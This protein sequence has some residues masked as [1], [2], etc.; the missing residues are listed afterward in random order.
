M[1][2]NHN[3]IFSQWI[4]INFESIILN[5]KL[6]TCRFA[7][8][9]EGKGK[10][11]FKIKKPQVPSSGNQQYD[12][13]APCI[14]PS[15]L[16]FWTGRPWSRRRWRRRACR[17]WRG[18]RWPWLPR[19]SCRRPCPAVWRCPWPRSWPPAP[20]SPAPPALARRGPCRR[21]SGFYI[22]R[23]L[24]IGGGGGGGRN[25]L[26]PRYL[27]VPVHPTISFIGLKQVKWGIK[28]EKRMIWGRLKISS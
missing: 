5:P 2:L 20:P 4:E 28:S 6:D 13:T 26:D 16:T 22:N 1:D 17:G 15:M 8:D 18:G 12:L 21:P 7:V 25:L 10:R 23:S 3:F 9:N 27:D 24:L 19:W 11:H 14:L